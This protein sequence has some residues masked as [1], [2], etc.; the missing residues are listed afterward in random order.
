[1][2]FNDELITAFYFEYM[3][4]PTL[5]E[6]VSFGGEWEHTKT[7]VSAKAINIYKNMLLNLGFETSR[8]GKV[9]K[10]KKVN[11]QDYYF[12]G[13]INEVCDELNVS[14]TYF[15]KCYHNNILCSHDYIIST[16]PVTYEHFRKVHPDI[17]EKCNK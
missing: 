9:Y 3:R 8:K 12:V 7:L 6:F 16:I 14:R 17:Y 11:D 10:L 13:N 5:E 15:L 1:M 2:N 4:A